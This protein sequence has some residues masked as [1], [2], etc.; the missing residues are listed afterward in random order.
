MELKCP[1]CEGKGC[2]GCGDSGVFTIARC[3]YLEL[4]DAA[5]EITL[6]A[7]AWDKGVLPVAGGALDQVES[8]WEAIQYALSEQAKWDEWRWQKMSKRHGGK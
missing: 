1:D 4:D 2:A 3:P 7:A 6:M 5:R 8:G